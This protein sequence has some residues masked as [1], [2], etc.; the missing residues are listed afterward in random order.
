MF[1]KR[2]CV[3]NDES[4]KQE[5]L[6][7]AHNSAYAMHLGGKKMYRTL[8]EYYWWPNM[9]REI[10]ACVSRC[11]VCQQVKVERQK[12]SGLLQTLLIPEWKWEHITMDF[13]HKLPRTQDGNDGILVI[14]DRLTKSAH[15][16]VVMETFSLDKLA[17]LYVNEIVRLHGVP[18]SIVL[19]IIS[20]SHHDFGALLSTLRL[21]D[22]LRGPFRPWK[23]CVVR[24]GKHGKLSH[25]YIG[26]YKIVGQVGL[27][28]YRL[29][30]PRQ[31]SKIH[32]VFHES[33]LHKYVADLSH[34]LPAQP[35][36]LREDLTYEE[37]PVQILD[38]REQVL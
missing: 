15:F 1:G 20:V 26:P 12:P 4:F 2:L 13:I 21:M 29:A 8:N 19:I 33:M 38:H 11:F 9:K 16:L 23:T 17:R 3:P 32:N 28:A 25:R 10:V 18:E 7:E 35:I 37:E 24:F 14:V 34:V 22:N 6:D 31:L 36:T 30:L 5:I 27:V